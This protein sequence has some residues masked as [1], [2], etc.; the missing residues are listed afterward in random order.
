MRWFILAL[1]LVGCAAT[2]LPAPV[3]YR[4]VIEADP[5]IS[6]S[7]RADDAAVRF[8]KNADADDLDRLTD[9]TIKK[10][11][12]VARARAHPNAKT[13]ARLGMRLGRRG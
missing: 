11:A 10:N 12:A 2:P 8:A 7:R 13:G 4:P 6:A 3:H 5:L 1:T 9:L